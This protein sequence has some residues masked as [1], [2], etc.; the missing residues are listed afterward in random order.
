MAGDME[1]TRLTD[2]K[3]L[4]FLGANESFLPGQLGSGGLLSEYD[5]EKIRSGGTEL[6]AGGKEQAYIQKFY[7]YT[8]LTKPQE[9]LYLSYASVAADG[10]SLRPSYL[11]RDIQKLFPRLTV[12]VYKRQVL[13]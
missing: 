9:L 3:A 1:R 13:V 7:L 5:R 8:M 10:T 2:I 11:I 6:S 12:D 4:F